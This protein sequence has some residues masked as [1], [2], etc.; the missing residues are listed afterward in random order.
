MPARKV[1]SF[2]AP[3]QAQSDTNPPSEPAATATILPFRPRRGFRLIEPGPCT[4]A[5]TTQNYPKACPATRT[6]LE[7]RLRPWC[8]WAVCRGRGAF[9]RD[10]GDCH[11]PYWQPVPRPRVR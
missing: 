11:G 9:G 6:P 1:A 7:R 8:P 5:T 10:C 2:P 3:I 4:C